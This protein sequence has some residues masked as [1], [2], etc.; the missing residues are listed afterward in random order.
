MLPVTVMT[1]F[2]GGTEAGRG[3][4]EAKAGVPNSGD[5]A[6]NNDATTMALERTMNDPRDEIVDALPPA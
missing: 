2:T 6:T 4:G 3:D 1:V 5:A